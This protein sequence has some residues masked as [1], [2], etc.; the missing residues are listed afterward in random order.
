MR[1]THAET[2]CVN[3]PLGG[4]LIVETLIN[5][6][7]WTHFS[8]PEGAA[9][10]PSSGHLYS[11]SLNSS[12]ASYPNSANVSSMESSFH[13]SSLHVNLNSSFGYDPNAGIPEEEVQVTI[14]LWRN[15]RN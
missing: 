3:E 4:I 1:K 15:I 2:G 8:S 6:Q 9:G 13:N 11:S 7:I 12:Y 14:N 10:A 5:F